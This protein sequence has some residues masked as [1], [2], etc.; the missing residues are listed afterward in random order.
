M[1]RHGKKG[2]RTR[3]SDDQQNPASAGSSWFF[4][5]DQSK[6]YDSKGYNDWKYSKSDDKSYDYDSKSY[7]KKSYDKFYDDSSHIG[8]SHGEKPYGKDY[9]DRGRNNSWYDDKSSN[10]KSYHPTQRIPPPPP[11]PSPRGGKD[12]TQ[13]AAHPGTPSQPMKTSSRRRKDK[14]Q[15]TDKES[16]RGGSCGGE[17]MDGHV[18][19]PDDEPSQEFK[20]GDRLLVGAEATEVLVSWVQTQ[21]LDSWSLGALCRN[22][23][24]S[25]L[26]EVKECKGVTSVAWE[27]FLPAADSLRKRCGM[28]LLAQSRPQSAGWPARP[29]SLPADC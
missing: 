18:A 1:S 12:V 24:E 20:V 6:Q 15:S 22:V 23:S 8:K 17:E 21:T 26:F 28:A 7:D 2:V 16:T 5:R 29:Y 13:N 25:L 4:G 10:V 14:Q 11:P 27:S 9:Y 3:G 19:E